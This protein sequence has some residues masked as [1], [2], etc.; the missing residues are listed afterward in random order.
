[1]PLL[2]SRSADLFF[3]GVLIR[4]VRQGKRKEKEG[5]KKWGKK[6]VFHK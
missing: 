2:I 1:M 4:R 5:G 3:A 6:G